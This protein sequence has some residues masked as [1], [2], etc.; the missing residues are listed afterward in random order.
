MARRISKQ[1]SIVSQASTPTAEVMLSVDEAAQRI[2]MSPQYVRRLVGERR[3]VFYRFGRSVRF[4]P[5]DVD[6]YVAAARVDRITASDVW[7]DVRRVS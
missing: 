4:M 6:E 1:P 3:I 2:R 5:A 7:R